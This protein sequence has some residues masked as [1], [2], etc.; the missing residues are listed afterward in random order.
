MSSSLLNGDNRPNRGT[1]RLLVDVVRPGTHGGRGVP[2][3]HPLGELTALRWRPLND[4][5]TG[6]GLL[7]LDIGETFGVILGDGL[8]VLFGVVP[9]VLGSNS[10]MSAGSP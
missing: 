6:D 9:G 1:G 5:L 10:G 8:G 7:G 2:H 4:N 3:P